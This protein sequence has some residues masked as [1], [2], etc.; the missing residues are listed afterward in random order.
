MEIQTH[1]SS[2]LK[3][4]PEAYAQCVVA[5]LPLHP[6]PECAVLQLFPPDRVYPKISIVIP[7]II[8]G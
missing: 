8:N 2:P 6:L 4:P 7:V 5:K 1:L 3:R